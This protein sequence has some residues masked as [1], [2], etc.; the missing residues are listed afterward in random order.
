MTWA[1]EA[2]GW[3]VKLDC[4]ERNCF[5]EYLPYHA[6]TP[7]FF[8]A[9]VVPPGELARLRIGMK[10]AEARALAPGVVD[11]RSGIATGVDGELFTHKWGPPRWSEEGGK[12]ILVFREGQPRVEVREDTENDV[13][14]LQ[15]R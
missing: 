3:K 4:L 12:P 9:H 7:D 5:I 11:V 1:S 13:W 6:L 2:T 10:L 15:I 8:G 14:R